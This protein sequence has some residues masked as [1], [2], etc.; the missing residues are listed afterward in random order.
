LSFNLSSEDA[1]AMISRVADNVPVTDVFEPNVIN[2]PLSEMFE[3]F[4]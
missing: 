4:K 1:Y 3:S 2:V